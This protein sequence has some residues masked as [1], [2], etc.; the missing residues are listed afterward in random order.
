[1]TQKELKN[2]YNDIV[3]APCGE[4]LKGWNCTTYDATVGKIITDDGEFDRKI[5][6]LKPRGIV[7]IVSKEKFKIPH[8]ITGITTLRTT[9]TRQG[10]L[11]LT[12]GIVDPGYEGYLSTAVIN[13]GKTS[14]DIE[15]GDKFF[16]TAFFKHKEVE[17]INRQETLSN[18]TRGVLKDRH[19][20][21]DTFLNIDSL[22]KEISGKI[23]TIPQWGIRIGAIAIGLSLLAIV[24]G[25]ISGIYN[26]I[27]INQ[28]K[29]NNALERIEVLENK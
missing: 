26:S 4:E 1:M 16:R 15:K 17:G 28:T 8:T 29:L 3:Q 20:F 11:T 6:V 27:Y 7:W 5:Y 10:L 2:D 9:W 23:F 21:A 24:L 25:S 14:F 13:F 22:T 19:Y 12:V 18:Y